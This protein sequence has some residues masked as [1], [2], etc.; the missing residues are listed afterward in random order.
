MLRNSAEDGSATPGHVR[1]STFTAVALGAALVLTL[2]GCGSSGGQGTI[3][4]EF[5]L[6]SPQGTVRLTVGSKDFT[7]QQI[8]GEITI[9]ALEAAGAEVID[10]TALGGTEEVRVALAS[11]GIDMYW[12]YTGTGWLVHLAEPDRISEPEKL[13]EAVAG[14]DS[15]QNGIEWLKPAP[16]NNTY[17]IAVREGTAE[18]LGVE[19]ISDLGA[20]IEERPKEATLCVGPEFDSRADGLP[21]LQRHYGFEFPEDQ[22]FEISATTVYGAVEKGET[23]TFGSVF[24]TNGRIGELRLQLLEDD[25]GFFAAYNPALTMRKETLERYPELEDLFASISEKL[26]T[27]A[28]R[29]LSAGVEVE[30]NR[31]AD[32]A[33]RWLQDNGFTS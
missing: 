23:C 16:A 10:K 27:E 25:E 26:D 18:D 6:S 28:L 5:E 31:P 11:G 15:D 12:E 9:Q 29:Q 22:V 2:G 13:Y 33:E 14:E 8:L 4:D 3:A 7:E 21:G 19:N 32:V 1:S 20:L 17:S 30:G 24:R